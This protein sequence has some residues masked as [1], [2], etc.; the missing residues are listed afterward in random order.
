MRRSKGFTCFEDLLDLIATWTASEMAF[1][2]P[3]G[4]FWIE[5]GPNL[6]L[7]R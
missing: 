1:P 4:V 2:T 3:F 6:R 5:G 7:V